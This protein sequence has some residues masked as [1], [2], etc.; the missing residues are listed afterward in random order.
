[1]RT[2]KTC[3]GIGATGRKACA[4]VM[5]QSKTCSWS[6]ILHFRDLI[7]KCYYINLVSVLNN[8]DRRII[9]ISLQ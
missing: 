2:S 1:M 9:E 8:I 7:P 6:D 5:A 3:P 4:V